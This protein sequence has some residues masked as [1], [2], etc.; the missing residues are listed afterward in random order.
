MQATFDNSKEFTKL[1]AIVSLFDPH[2]VLKCDKEGIRIFCLDSSKTQVLECIL[3]TSFFKTY[4]YE[5]QSDC[6]K[7]GIHASVFLDIIKGIHKTDI[8]HLIAK[9]ENK[10]QVQVDGEE[11][12]MAYDITLMSIIDET[13]DIPEIDTNIKMTITDD[14]LKGWKTQICDRTGESLLFHV[15]KDMLQLTSNGTY[16]NVTSTLCHGQKMTILNCNEPKDIILSQRSIA[17]AYRLCDISSKIQYQ[18]TNDAP[19]CFSC[20]IGRSGTIKMWF[21]PE[22]M[23]D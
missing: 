14:I 11:L 21:A 19:A 6:M 4:T 3:P 10:M 8:F 12:Q 2:F 22:M 15:Q 5:G 13:M 9:N 7:L 1:I 23:D 17:T 20:V 18:W 16:L